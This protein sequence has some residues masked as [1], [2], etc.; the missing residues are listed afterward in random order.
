MLHPQP[1]PALLPHA[2]PKAPQVGSRGWRW[3]Y[4]AEDTIVRRE[5][6]GEDQLIAFLRL[7]E[8]D[9]P[10]LEGVFPVLFVH[11][12]AGEWQQG[13]HLAH[14]FNQKEFQEL[15]HAKV[16]MFTIDFARRQMAC[17]GDLLGQQAHFVNQCIRHILQDYLQGSVSSVLVVGHSMGGLVGR[18][19]MMQ[20]N[21]L[22]G[23]ISALITLGTPHRLTSLQFDRTL[24]HFYW[25]LQSFLDTQ[26][27]AANSVPMLSI[28]GGWRDTMIAGEAS[29]LAT[30]VPESSGLFVLTSSIPGLWASVDHDGLYSC[31]Q[32]LTIVARCAFDIM[33]SSEEAAIEP[34][35]R[36]HFTSN[37][38]QALAL[39]PN[40][41]DTAREVSP[42]GESLK[43]DASQARP[44][45]AAHLPLLV[46][47][48]RDAGNT[49]SILLRKWKEQHSH[50]MLV[51]ATT[52][53][54]SALTVRL[55]NEAIVNRQ[56]W[57]SLV[58]DTAAERRYMPGAVPRTTQVLLL[59][60]EQLEEYSEVRIDVSP[61]VGDGGDQTKALVQIFN[62]APASTKLARPT[63]REFFL[64]SISVVRAVRAVPAMQLHVRLSPPQ[65]M[66]D[67]AEPLFPPTVFQFFECR[68]DSRLTMWEE[69]THVLPEPGLVPLL[70]AGATIRFHTR[71]IPAAATDECNGKGHHLVLLTDPRFSYQVSLEND[72]VSYVTVFLP[73]YV[74]LLI[75]SAFAWYFAALAYQF[76]CWRVI[77]SFPPLVASLHRLAAHFGWL[78]VAVYALARLFPY[79][80]LQSIKSGEDVLSW[81]LTTDPDAALPSHLFVR[82]AKR[83]GHAWKL[84]VR[85]AGFRLGLYLLVALCSLVDSLYAWIPLVVILTA[86]RPNHAQETSGWNFRRT[87]AVL[88]LLRIVQSFVCL[89][90]PLKLDVWARE[91]RFDSAVAF[92][93]APLLFGCHALSITNAALPKDRLMT[94]A[95][96][97]CLVYIL[98]FCMHAPFKITTVYSSYALFLFVYVAF[99]RWRKRNGLA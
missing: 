22:P 43:D 20:S 79:F 83:A 2:R 24:F 76:Y 98:L 46:L 70:A 87:W 19:T 89:N 17:R 81:T 44:A 61:S 21:F 32:L 97:A 56:D 14:V 27:E 77:G 93:L 53:P 18:A 73:M 5:R 68:N 65:S 25:E 31:E 85:S 90:N 23:S 26:Q 38:P 78:F 84:I 59:R 62:A 48:G 39:R 67:G 30:V 11:G 88:F 7:E 8:L 13:N 58:R 10:H 74:A 51:I 45:M 47:G 75:P 82:A 28:S 63:L 94:Y 29:V 55:I 35:F 92:A 9:Q 4:R 49:Y 64:R 66:S 95:P 6:K 91:F 96:V 42:L 12:H 69:A 37:V 40:A 60:P 72:Y 86:Y 3:N 16:R 80:Q 50:P 99:H 36:K 71:A 57:A 41:P 54:S 15:N 34:L 52:W 1:P 33:T